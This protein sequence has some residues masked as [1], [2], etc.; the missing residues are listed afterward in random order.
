M[1]DTVLRVEHLSK[2][3]PGE[4]ALDDVSM[5]LGAHEVV[6]IVGENGAGK[7]TL[8][9]VLSGVCQPDGGR[10]VV[11]GEPVRLD[12]ARAAAAAGIGMVFQEQSLLP[13]LSV[14][15]NI[16][17]GHED[18]AMRAGFYRWRR[19]HALAAAQLDKLGSH[20]APSAPTSSLSFAERQVVEWAKALAIAER[21]PHEP[22]L[23]LDEP[24][25]M[26]DAAQV[27]KVLSLIERLRSRASIIFVSHRLDEVLRVCERIYVMAAGRCVAQRDGRACSS[28]ELQELMLS[29]EI[30]PRAARAAG[31]G[32][33]ARHDAPLLSVQAL[34]LAPRYR[35]VSFDLHSGQV[36]GLAGAAGSGRESL[37]RAL[38]GA[39]APDSGEI[40]VDGKR[41][42]FDEPADAVA[43]GIGYVPAERRAEGIVAG[44]SMADNMTLA[45]SGALR[46]GPFV[47]RRREAELVRGWIARLRIKPADPR[48]PVQFLSGGNQQKVVLAKWLIARPPRLLI[49]DHPLRGLD[50][51]ARSE[52]AALIGELAGSGIA[53]VLVAD[54]ADELISL[55]DRVIVMKDGAVTDAFDTLDAVAPQ[56]S[57]SGT[58]RPPELRVL[59]GML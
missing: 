51:G 28:A 27:D 25:S 32:P 5:E 20:I 10:I 36:L 26:L 46:R 42:T 21:S 8:L 41:V 44:L 6:G 47:A 34:G 14:A 35:A 38:F 1:K 11:R 4:R 9:K 55:C 31:A 29:R 24:T 18:A 54:T 23:L 33:A 13:N 7:S 56:P 53:I 57:S 52:M 43:L 17:L 15:E 19:L 3:Y 37:C 49:L 40:R 45:Q 12:S 16:M 39:E 2:A 59:Q 30:A 48:L 58:A 22:I 50:V